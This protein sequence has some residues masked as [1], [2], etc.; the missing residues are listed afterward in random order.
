MQ[1][2]IR[3]QVGDERLL[4]LATL[5]LSSALSLVLFSFRVFYAGNTIYH[6]LIWNLFLAWIPLWAALTLWVLNQRKR[7]SAGV[8]GALLLV[9]FLFLPN[10]PYLITDLV[11]LY[12][13]ED[14]P[15]WYDLLMLY[16]FAWNGL[17]VGFTSLYVVQ[18]M[19]GCWTNSTVGWLFAVLTIAATSFGIYLGRFL[20]WNSWDVLTDPSGLLFD[21][22][23]RFV[24][25]LSHPR[26]LGVTLIL[27]AF[28][29]L[30]YVTIT[31]LSRT[32]WVP[33]AQD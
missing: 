4:L 10:A 14:I 6:F 20:R 9:W 7:R 18:Q 8:M 21:I 32:R 19:V 25:P 29:L 13:F 31:L 5:A 30:A 23:H 12:S 26:T 15:W 16:S 11:H 24:D 1:Q 22:V 3:S 28:L 27:S 33:D 17:L 2:V